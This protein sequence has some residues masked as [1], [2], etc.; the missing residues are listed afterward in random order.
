MTI[1]DANPMIVPA[2]LTLSIIALA[3]SRTGFFSSE[4]IKLSQ[5]PANWPMWGR[6]YYGQRYSELYQ[7]NTDRSLPETSMVDGDRSACLEAV[8]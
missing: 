8:P 4:L 3:I 6:N 1:S 5:N 7:I 2:R